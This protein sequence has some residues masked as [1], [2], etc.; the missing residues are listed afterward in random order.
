[1][2]SFSA[3]R[4]IRPIE[5]GEPMSKKR[6][7]WS[8]DATNKI[9]G[10]FAPRLAEMLRS[11]SYRVLSLAAHRLLARIEIELSHHSGSAAAAREANGRGLPVTYAHLEE[12]GIHH[13]SIA[14][15]IRESV[16]LGFVEVMQRGCG[17]NASFKK[18][19][20]YRLTYR[21]AVGHPGDGS[22]EW[23]QI[24]DLQTAEALAAQARGTVSTVTPKIKGWGHKVTH[25]W[26]GPLGADR[27]AISI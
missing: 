6:S 26:S 9:S 5:G 11:P 2:H 13:R 1:M 15:A 10:Y 16:A 3:E 7:V 23:R 25:D 24:A 14:P 12:Y 8:K 18:L 22:H 19:N 4:T 17:G 21:P 27:A 20:T